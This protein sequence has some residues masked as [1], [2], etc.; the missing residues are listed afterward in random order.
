M[1]KLGTFRSPRWG[2]VDVL[3]GRYGSADGPLAVTLEANFAPLDTIS[4]N[5][6]RPQ[7]SHDSRDLPADCFYVRDYGDHAK[8]AQ[9]AFGSGLF[10]KR[11]DLPRAESGY[12]T[13][14]VWQI[15]PAVVLKVFGAPEAQA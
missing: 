5:M 1:K 12:I 3:I 13:A 10:V 15:K 2:T 6:Y 14:G 11:D 8:M 4:V 9:E 7:C